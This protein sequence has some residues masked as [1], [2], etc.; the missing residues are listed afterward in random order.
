MPEIP[1]KGGRGDVD[2]PSCS[3]QESQNINDNKTKKKYQQRQKKMWKLGNML[4][5]LFHL[6][7]RRNTK[8]SLESKHSQ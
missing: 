8:S 1:A 4:R 5:H 3:S 6:P 2:P 7:I